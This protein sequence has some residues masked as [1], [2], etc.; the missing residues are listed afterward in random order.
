MSHIQLTIKAAK[1]PELT[2]LITSGDKLCQ[3]MLVVPCDDYKAKISAFVNEIKAL[4]M[5]DANMFDVLQPL[6][7]I[8][9]D[10]KNPLFP[11]CWKKLI[12][13]YK[14]VLAANKLFNMFSDMNIRHRDVQEN[15]WK[16]LKV[17]GSWL[18]TN[19]PLYK[20]VSNFI[21]SMENYEVRSKPKLFVTLHE[22]LEV[23]SDAPQYWTD[24]LNDYHKACQF[25]HDNDLLCVSNFHF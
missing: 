20:S 10:H 14:R 5:D 21:V 23:T 11:Q 3:E 17:Q 13:R 12:R 4:S 15:T 9:M 18:N 25:I 24:Y 1:A 16:D 22:K 2:A 7:R 6:Y 19:Q 8:K